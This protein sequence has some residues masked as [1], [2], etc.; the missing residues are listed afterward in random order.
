MRFSHAALRGRVRR[1]HEVG[2]WMARWFLTRAV[3]A[4]EA[5]LN[6]QLAT[7]LSAAIIL[8]N[9][10]RM[11]NIGTPEQ[12]HASKNSRGCSNVWRAAKL[13]WLDS[14]RLRRFTACRCWVPENDNTSK[15]LLDVKGENQTNKNG[16]Y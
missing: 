5:I 14:Q 6:P 12:W 3:L 2:W 13:P 9:G 11:P 7:T 15:V 10:C 8:K 1:G 4:W 16:E